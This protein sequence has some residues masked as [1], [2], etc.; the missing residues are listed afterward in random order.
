MGDQ[1]SQL[2]SDVDNLGS[3]VGEVS[4]LMACCFQAL[5]ACNWHFIPDPIRNCAS[6]L[7]LAELQPCLWLN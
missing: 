4:S 7:S 3:N 5:K 2:G 6:L 1:L